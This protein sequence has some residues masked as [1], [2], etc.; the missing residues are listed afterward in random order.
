LLFGGATTTHCAEDEEEDGKQDGGDAE[1]EKSDE[2]IR[3]ERR[4]RIHAGQSGL[5]GDD[6]GWPLGRLPV[7][8][9]SL[10][11]R[12]QDQVESRKRR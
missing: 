12:K 2:E 1:D 10:G 8:R 6:N 7:Q 3:G 9:E 11:N 4:E 5:Y